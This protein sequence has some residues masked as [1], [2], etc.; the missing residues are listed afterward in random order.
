MNNDL[1]PALIPA[2]KETG[3]KE[4]TF[5]GL[6]PK[7][8]ITKESAEA[9]KSIDSRDL[10]KT[11]FVQKLAYLLRMLIRNIFKYKTSARVYIYMNL[12]GVFAHAYALV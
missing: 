9:W 1:P 3:I 10:K 8:R 2:R 11:R 5:I 7:R 6:N 4:S 12:V